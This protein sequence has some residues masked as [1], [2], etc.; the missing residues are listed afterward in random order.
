MSV[1][2]LAGAY[3][4]YTEDENGY[5]TIPDNPISKTGVFKYLGSSIS[6]NLEPNKVYNVYRPEEELNNP[7]TIESFKLTPWIPSHVMLGDGYTAAEKVGVEGVTGEKVEYRD[8][9]LYSKLKLFGDNLKK[10]IK[11]GLKQLSCGFRCTWDITS[12]ITP[13]GEEYDIIQREIRGN[14]LAS[15]GA[16]RMGADIRVAMDQAHFALDSIDFNHKETGEHMNDAQKLIHQ[17]TA[18]TEVLAKAQT[19]MDAMSEKMEVLEKEAKTRSAEDESHG[20]K[21]RNYSKNGNTTLDE[22]SKKDKKDESHGEKDRNYSKNGETALDADSDKLKIKELFGMVEDLKKQ[23][24]KKGSATDAADM[25]SSYNK[26]QTLAAKVS[27]LI[28]AFDSSA[29]DSDGVAKYWSE[30]SGV[31]CD[32]G[33][34]LAT[35]N[36]FLAGQQTRTYTAAP[37][38]S[39][40]ASDIAASQSTSLDDLGL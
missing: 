30:K 5:I 40:D 17:L 31:A 8:G 38:V 9:V 11:A 21:D 12:G 34:E 27:A 29:M 26:T 23:L 18:Q 24:A 16:A 2:N 33:A 13:Q 25:I 10:M 35:L 39:L 1:I 3:M 22:Q 32:S 28:G 4:R 6:P 37:A 36:G 15:V 19:A 20:E 14:H 7:K